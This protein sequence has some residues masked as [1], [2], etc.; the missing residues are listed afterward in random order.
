MTVEI[1]QGKT[2]QADNALNYIHQAEIETLCNELKE[3][4][5]RLDTLAK[6]IRE[7]RD[8]CTKDNLQIENINYED[9]LQACAEKYHI[10]SDYVEEFAENI[11]FLTEKTINQKQYELNEQAR[12]LDQDRTRGEV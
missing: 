9:T 4:A 8:Y 12:I 7:A 3:Q 5:K 2:I 10:I 11:S 1:Y 6:K